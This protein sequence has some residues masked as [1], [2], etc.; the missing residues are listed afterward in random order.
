LLV[1]PCPAVSEVGKVD[2]TRARTGLA[3][4]KQRR[5]FADSRPA[6][7]SSIIHI[8]YRSSYKAL[9]TEHRYARYP[10]SSKL[11]AT[12]ENLVKRTFDS[13]RRSKPFGNRGHRDL[14]HRWE[15]GLSGTSRNATAAHA[16]ACRVG[17][18]LAIRHTSRKSGRICV[19]KRDHRNRQMKHQYHFG[20]PNYPL[21]KEV[22]QLSALVSNLDRVVRVL[23]SDIAAEEER[24][25]VS[26]PQNAA[27]PSL[28]RM[29]TA[30]RNNLKETIGALER[31]LFSKQSK[32][33]VPA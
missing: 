5:R 8:W 1:N 25:G 4:K 24:S 2:V 13:E 30:R 20:S 14:S 10:F 33:I 6:V 23:D 16:R 9:P 19:Q 22:A 32:L 18:V 11:P 26:D 3:P 17:K 31:R 28:A 12:C 21:L 7:G 29:M 27:Y 15:S